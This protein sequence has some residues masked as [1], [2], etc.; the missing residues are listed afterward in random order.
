MSE[1]T[2]I[3]PFTK[4]HFDFDS[5]PFLTNPYKQLNLQAVGL[6]FIHLPPDEGY[7]FTHS[8]A[9]QE[10]V[11]I[12]VQ[13]QGTILVDG[14]LI[15][16]ERGDCVRVSPS[17]KRAL[18]ADKENALLVIC[19]GGVAAG[20]PKNSNSR[21]LIDDGIPDYDDIPPWYEGNPEVAAKNAQLK[22]RMLKS[23]A[24]RQQQDEK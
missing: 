20:Y 22:E 9:E 23:Q 17:A 15:P 24:K 5:L 3:N 10:E 16:I 6:G 11:Y 18:K 4:A 8:H 14:E 7:T 21:Y 13:G 19:A 2:N 12:V 1:N